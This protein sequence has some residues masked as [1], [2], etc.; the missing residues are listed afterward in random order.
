MYDSYLQLP[1]LLSLQSPRADALGVAV[2]DSELYFITVH[3]S[4]EILAQQLLTDLE[5][6]AVSAVDGSADWKEIN[7]RLR[8][9]ICLVALQRELLRALDHLPKEHFLAFRPLLGTASGAAS[10]QFA[11]LFAMFGTDG[12]S[13][14]WPLAADGDRPAPAQ[15]EEEI[16][17]LREELRM[18]QL[19]HVQL[20]ERMIGDAPGTGGSAGARW[21][22]SRVL[23][24]PRVHSGAGH[25]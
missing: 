2:H 25:R 3:Q 10:A 20:V 4:A 21:L 22:L 5:A 7:T 24:T 14:R 9:A 12:H 13:G 19:S 15:I 17:A 1:T 6:V 23:S 18:W 8:R 16:G 11:A